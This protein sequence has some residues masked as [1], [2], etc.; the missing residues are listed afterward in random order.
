MNAPARHPRFAPGDRLDRLIVQER[1]GRD[2]NSEVYRVFHPDF[3]RDMAIKVFHPDVT[4]TENLGG[5]FRE[6]AR[7]I[8]ALRH[9]NILRVLSADAVGQLY[10]LLMELIEGSTLRDEI[11]AHPTGLPREEVLRLFRQIASAV[12]YAHDLEIV[13]GNL[14]PDNVLL[15]RTS[16][17]ILTDFNIPCFREHPTGRG[18][19]GTP[20]YLAPEQATQKNLTVQSDIYALGILLYEMVT[21]DVPFK[22]PSYEAIIEQHLTASPKPPS[23]MRVGLDPRIEETILKALNKRPADRFASVREMLSNLEASTASSPYETIS[24]PPE[25]MAKVVKHPAEI[26]QFESARAVLDK[27]EHARAAGLHLDPQ[28]VSLGLAILAVVLAVAILA[29]LLL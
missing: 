18:G 28:L 24:L 11:T 6:Q 23:Q 5:L 15:D 22:G 17:P 21:G 4:L 20:L 3:R 27:P 26:R 12:A 8:I 19:A 13:H 29:V 16:R 10:Y 25:L 2:E 7:Q 14:K 9:P 1:L